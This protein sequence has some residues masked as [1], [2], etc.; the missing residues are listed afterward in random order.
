MYFSR[1]KSILLVVLAF[2]VFNGAILQG[3]SDIIM[4]LK[5]VKI[6][7]KGYGK[8]VV[9]GRK[10]ERF[11]V[12]VLGILQNNKINESMLINGYSILVKVSGDLIKKAGGIASGMSGSPV[13]VDHKLIG[14][15][16]SGWLLTDH[17]VG[18]VTP[19]E[20]MLEI[21]NYPDISLASAENSNKSQSKTLDYANLPKEWLA[22]HPVRLGGKEIRIIRELQ[23][24]IPQKEI[25]EEDGV[26]YF[27]T[28]SGTVE[29]AG[30]S[31]RAAEIFKQRANRANIAV[32]SRG[33]MYASNVDVSDNLKDAS[34][35]FEPGSSLGIQLARGDLSMSSL[36]TMT[37]R[38]GH[39][40]LALAHSFLKKGTVA[41]LMTGAFIHHSF[42]SVEMPFKIGAPSEMLGIITQDREKGLAGHVGVLPE[43]V[44]ITIDVY[45]KDIKANKSINYQIV[46]DPQIFAMVLESTLVQGLEG[47]MDRSG[48][49]TAQMSVSLDCQTQDGKTTNFRRENLFYSRND[50]IQALTTEVCGLIDMV[51]E[52]EH[53]VVM[54]SRLILKVEVE[55]RRRTVQIERVEVKNTSISS[56]GLLEVDVILKPFR[57]KKIVRRVRLPVPND[58]GREN[59]VLSV[60]GPNTKFEEPEGLGNLFGEVRETKKDS[61]TAD[62]ASGVGFESAIRSWVNS[63]KNSDLLFQ[64]TVEGE[65]GKKIKFNDKDFEIQP[66]SS[67]VSG[68]IDTSLTLSEE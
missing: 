35:A 23:S 32:S 9:T 53:H 11:D 41:Y 20:E 28:V 37:H 16:S 49:G 59:L 62:E 24:T 61:R 19:I 47:V 33:M 52:N 50:I 31:G 22:K 12:E 21:W 54:P 3:Q 38:K 39:R 5:D 63:P 8:T 68:R 34:E 58:I 25:K 43:M 7:M 56:G 1:I 66:T 64:L 57:D 17:T 13:Y 18:L 29:V 48:G 26:A 6:G 30:L 44:P 40:I 45:D 67:V 36:G 42:A 15:L 10:I 55:R 14:G 60:F 2:F 65:E 51:T 46:K 4:P 27:K